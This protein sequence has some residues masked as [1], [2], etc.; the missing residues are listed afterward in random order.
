MN[1]SPTLAVLE[2][3]EFGAARRAFDDPNWGFEIKYDGYRAL[4]CTGPHAQLK[5]RRGTDASERFE[6][7]VRSLRA[8]RG[9]NVIDGEVAVLDETGRSDFE[10][11]QARARAKGWRRGLPLVVYCAFDLLVYCGRDVRGKPLVERKTAL[12]RLL[13]GSLPS[14]LYVERIVGEG[15]WLFEHVLT[16]KL[17]GMVAKRLDSLYLSGQRTSDWLKVKRQG[18]VPVERLRRGS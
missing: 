8:L 9:G 11:L 17:E 1:S 16:L 15:R 14:L 10:A 4:S 18:A 3:M 7:V 13:R 2:P 12:R 5:T 6:E